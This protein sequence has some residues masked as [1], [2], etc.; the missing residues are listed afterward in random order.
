MLFKRNSFM[1]YTV[2]QATLENFNSIEFHIK[3]CLNQVDS[4]ILK[5]MLSSVIPLHPEV[6]SKWA[7]LTPNKH[8]LIREYKDKDLLKK[9]WTLKYHI[10]TNLAQDYNRTVLIAYA[11][12]FT[13]DIYNEDL[14]DPERRKICNIQEKIVLTLQRYLYATNHN[15]VAFSYFLQ[16]IETL[17]KLREVPDILL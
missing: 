14:S 8:V 5:S 12:L 13:S 9:Y 17:I 3:K 7:T 10:R 1:V 11:V 6:K 15:S 2:I 16:S 4:S